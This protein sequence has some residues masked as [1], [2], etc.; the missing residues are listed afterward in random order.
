MTN[1][2]QVHALAQLFARHHGIGWDSPR[3][4][5]VVWIRKALL[6]MNGR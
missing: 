1:F 3:C 4:R 6:V 5:H 2:F